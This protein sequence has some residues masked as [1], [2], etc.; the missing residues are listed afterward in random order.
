MMISGVCNDEVRW[1]KYGAGNA[2]G[3]VILID[4]N[5]KIVAVDFTAEE[6][7]EYL[8]KLIP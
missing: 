1:S 6:L 8:K 2:G 3:K 5:G 4:R 7:E